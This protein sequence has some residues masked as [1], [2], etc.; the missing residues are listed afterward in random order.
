MAI[1][2]EVKKPGDHTT[3]GGSTQATHQEGKLPSKLLEHG[4][5]KDSSIGW[6]TLPEASHCCHELIRCRGGSRIF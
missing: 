4:S 3:N 6:T 5:K 1:Y 2:A